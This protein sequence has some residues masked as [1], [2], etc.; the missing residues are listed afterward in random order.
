MHINLPLKH[1]WLN[2]PL[3]KLPQTYLILFGEKG[4]TQKHRA[5]GSNGPSKSAQCQGPGP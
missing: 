5:L 3:A 2:Q 4:K 1:L